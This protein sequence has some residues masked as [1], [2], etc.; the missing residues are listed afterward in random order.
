MQGVAELTK[1]R[2]SPGYQSSGAFVVEWITPLVPSAA[3]QTPYAFL[4]NA[5]GMKLEKKDGP[6]GKSGD[7]LTRRHVFVYSLLLTRSQILSS[8]SSAPLLDSPSLS[9]FT[10]LLLSRY[11]AFTFSL[12]SYFLK[13]KLEPQVGRV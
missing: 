9:L 8:K 2:N 4:F 12:R 10:A 3:R 13:G 5:R 6:L 11:A 7:Y 1:L